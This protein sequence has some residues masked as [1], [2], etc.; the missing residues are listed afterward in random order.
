MSGGEYD[1]AYSAI[2][3]FAEHVRADTPQRVAFRDL[4][5]S[6]ADAAHAVEWVDSY[7]YAEG[8][9]DASIVACF[10]VLRK[11]ERATWMTELLEL[12]RSRNRVVSACLAQTTLSCSATSSS[13]T[14]GAAG[15]VEPSADST[16]TT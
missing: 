3:R 14:T 13:A 12:Q 1:Y 16:P 7:D 10:A 6:V 15:A 2:A 4:L 5:F 11:Y 9:E 8:E